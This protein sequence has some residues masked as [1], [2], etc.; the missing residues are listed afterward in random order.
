MQA[1]VPKHKITAKV[2][3]HLLYTQNGGF[4]VG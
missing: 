4:R 1:F 2:I 3:N